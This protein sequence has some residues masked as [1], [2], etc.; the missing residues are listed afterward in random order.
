[1]LSKLIAAT[2]PIVDYLE[3]LFGKAFYNYRGRDAGL[4]TKQPQFAGIAANISVTSTVPEVLPTDYYGPKPPMLFPPISVSIVL[5]GYL[6]SE[7]S[8]SRDGF[9]KLLL[10]T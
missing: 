3:H 10:T 9:W 8:C 6:S 4:F 7:L 5:C 2:Y 1:M